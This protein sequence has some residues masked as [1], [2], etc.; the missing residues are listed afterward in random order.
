MRRKQFT[1][2]WSCEDGERVA[3][4]S[5]YDDSGI[6]DDVWETCEICNGTGETCRYIQGN[7]LW[8]VKMWFRNLRYKLF[9][10]GQGEEE[11]DIPF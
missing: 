11:D 2:C 4:Y 10:R 8:V 9:P 1:D 6:V 5:M 3:G 7:I